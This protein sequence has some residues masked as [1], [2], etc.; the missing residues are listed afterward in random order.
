MQWLAYTLTDHSRHRLYSDCMWNLLFVKTSHI[1]NSEFN[2]CKCGWIKAG[3]GRINLAGADSRRRQI[4]VIEFL[5]ES[6]NRHIAFATYL[7]EN[8]DDLITDL[9][10]ILQG[11][12]LKQ[13]VL[14][15]PVEF[16]PNANF[17][18]HR[19]GQHLFDR[20]HKQRARTGRLEVLECFPE[21][22]LTT[23]GMHRH[24][25]TRTV[26]RYDRWRF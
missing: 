26:Q 3:N 1:A 15:C 14:R 24:L 12:A 4:H 19:S 13:P 5:R 18:A 2:S 25:V 17:D 16:V 8:R 10:I 22:V 9:R 23:H 6:A 7:V 21:H 11:R 20:Q